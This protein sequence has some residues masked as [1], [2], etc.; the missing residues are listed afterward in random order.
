MEGIE[1]KRKRL[2]VSSDGGG[3]L[4]AL[5]GRKMASRA[6]KSHQGTALMIL[7]QKNHRGHCIQS[8]GVLGTPCPSD[9]AE[10]TISP[11]TLLSGHK[12][13]FSY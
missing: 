13:Q 1:G 4:L 2:G 12:G 7:A 6:A 5:K 11:R 9:L 3:T 8:P 10:E